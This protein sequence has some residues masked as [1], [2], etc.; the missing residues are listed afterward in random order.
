MILDLDGAFVTYENRDN[1]EICV[2]E[3]YKVTEAQKEEIS[4]LLLTV[5]DYVNN[6]ILPPKTLHA[7][8]CKWCKY[9]NL[10]RKDES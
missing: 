2:P 4:S 7:S 9:K 3:L 8:A 1:C 6:E 5:E 10:C